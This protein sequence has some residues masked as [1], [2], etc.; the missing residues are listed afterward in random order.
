MLTIEDLRR[1][2]AKTEEGLGRC[3]NNEAFYLRL[4]KMALGDA[5]FDKLAAAIENGDRKA[6]FEAA[7]ALKGSLGNLALTP[8]YQPV[9]EL[10]ELLRGEEGPE[11][12]YGAYLAK[13]LE[14]RDAMA[15]LD[16]V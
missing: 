5:S 11:A 1:L 10:T 15:A 2:G 4:V 9:A 8:I 6:A 14:Q 12:D 3:M 7:H 16:K 13:I